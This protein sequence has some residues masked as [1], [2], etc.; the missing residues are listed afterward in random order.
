MNAQFPFAA[1]RR[2][3]RSL[4]EVVAWGRSPG[5]MDAF[6]R[7]FLDEF[8]SERDVQQS[9]CMLRDEPAVIENE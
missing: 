1:S 9:G 8:Y 7:E 5:E 6:L 3:P 2:R 4:K